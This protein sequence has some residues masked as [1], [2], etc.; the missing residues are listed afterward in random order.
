MVA[1]CERI[2]T[3]L[4]LTLFALGQILLALVFTPLAL[5]PL[6]LSYCSRYRE[7]M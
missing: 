4:H 3:I 1:T 7:I 5:V 2:R 6:S